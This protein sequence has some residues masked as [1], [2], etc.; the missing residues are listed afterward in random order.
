MSEPVEAVGAAL[1]VGWTA[2]K[3][4]VGAWLLVLIVG[5]DSAPGRPLPDSIA[6]HPK[7]IGL[8]RNSRITV[9]R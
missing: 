9:S 3:L 2:Q 7:L 8:M 1:G 5:V 6:K 4:E